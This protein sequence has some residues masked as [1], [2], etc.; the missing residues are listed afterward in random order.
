MGWSGA[1]HDAVALLI[2]LH[3]D[4]SI[5]RIEDRCAAPGLDGSEEHS[6]RRLAFNRCFGVRVQH[7]CHLLERIEAVIVVLPC[8]LPVAKL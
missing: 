7:I 2:D 6:L 5:N 8:D 1:A 4:I 3:S